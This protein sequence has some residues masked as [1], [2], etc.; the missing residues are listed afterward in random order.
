MGALLR[1]SRDKD[2]KFLMSLRSETI[3]KY[4][5]NEGLRADNVAHALRIHHR[6][7]SAN[8]VEVGGTPVGLLEYYHEHGHIIS[9]IQIA[10][11]QQGIG[12]GTRLIESL[13]EKADLERKSVLLRGLQSNSAKRLYERL[14]FQVIK[15]DEH[16]YT[17][18][19]T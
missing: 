12:L 1:P 16:E 7:E 2:L 15:T 18:E 6:F 10:P 14:G 4:L 17:M 9:Q 11:S 8:I 13:L 3:T 19:K 5:E